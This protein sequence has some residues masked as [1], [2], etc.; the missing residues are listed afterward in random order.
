MLE[1][2][3]IKEKSMS[4]FKGQADESVDFKWKP[5][6]IILSSLPVLCKWNSKAWMTADLFKCISYLEKGF[7]S[8]C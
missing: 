8:K 5:L 4:G 2:D 3:A 6:R 1:E 7:I